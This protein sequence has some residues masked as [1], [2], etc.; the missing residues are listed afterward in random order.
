M[1]AQMYE[2]SN[3]DVADRLAE[4]RKAEAD[5]TEPLRQMPHEVIGRVRAM[6]DSASTSDKVATRTAEIRR[7]RGVLAA[8]D[9]WMD[10]IRRSP[11]PGDD[12]DTDLT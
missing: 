8:F 3:G 4:L 7:A 6:L 10:D 1:T 11:G 5:M 2:P 12:R 9:L